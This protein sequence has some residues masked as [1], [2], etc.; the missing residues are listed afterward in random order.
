M[1]SDIV[2]TII[3]SMI[4]WYMEHSSPARQSPAVS[5]KLKSLQKRQWEHLERLSPEIV[6]KV[7]A[8]VWQNTQIDEDI[9]TRPPSRMIQEVEPP[10]RLPQT[11]SQKINQISTIFQWSGYGLGEFGRMIGSTKN[12]NVMLNGQTAL[13]VASYNGDIAKVE[14]LLSCEDTRLNECNEH[15][16]TAII[17][18]ALEGK[19]A[20]VRLLVADERLDVL[21][22][23]QW[24][25][26]IAI[27]TKRNRNP[28]I[29]E[30]IRSKIQEQ[31]G[32]LSIFKRLFNL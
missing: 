24:E 5:D 13:W 6:N 3:Y 4:F 29:A 28:R 26:A 1:L 32:W 16:N 31:K 14:L 27:A 23:N 15:G 2:I 12:V 19:Y 18:A 10:K 9:E 7:A 22:H 25:K 17:W 30:L 8:R 21:V 20:I 11:G